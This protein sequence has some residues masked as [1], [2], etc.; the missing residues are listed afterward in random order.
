MFKTNLTTIELISISESVKIDEIQGY[1]FIIASYS[2]P[3]E[4]KKS[5]EKRG[6]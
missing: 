5:Q 4:D 3:R 1:I 6:S 2:T